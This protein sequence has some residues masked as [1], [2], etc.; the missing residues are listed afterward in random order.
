MVDQNPMMKQE[1]LGI[2]KFYLIREVLFSFF[3]PL[4][5]NIYIYKD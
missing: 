4:S 3:D 2:N 5:C 1:V